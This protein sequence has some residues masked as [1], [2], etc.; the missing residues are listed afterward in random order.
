[1]R[2]D[3]EVPRPQGR[4]FELFA[5]ARLQFAQQRHD[6]LFDGVVEMAAILWCVIKA[7]SRAKGVL[8]VIAKPG[9]GG[10]FF[11]ELEQLLEYFLELFGLLQTP[12]GHQFPGLLAQRTIRLLQIAGHLNERFLFP[13]KLHGKR[14]AEFLVLLS[15]FGLLGFKRDILRAE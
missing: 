3:R 7:V 14:A 13:A 4:E 8:Q 11:P 6:L 15:E 10:D 2:I 12:V 5:A 1:M 9:V